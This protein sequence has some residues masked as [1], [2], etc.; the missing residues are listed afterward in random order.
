MKLS[1]ALQMK[2][3]SII[4]QIIGKIINIQ[5]TS[6]LKSESKKGY[7]L[8]KLTI[9]DIG[10][11]STGTILIWD[12]VMGYKMGRIY[13]WTG[14]RVKMNRYSSALETTYSTNILDITDSCIRDI[15]IMK[16]PKKILRQKSLF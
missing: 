4:S 8:T 15:T 14:L 6:Q 13:K 11:E 5:F 7:K 3:R 10:D 9:Q 16:A 1:T 12:H 2:N